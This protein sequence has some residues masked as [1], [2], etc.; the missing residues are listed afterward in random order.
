MLDVQGAESVQVLAPEALLIFLTTETEDE[1]VKRLK[2]R[3]GA[4]KEDLNL[5]IAMARQELKQISRFDYVVVNRENQLDDTVDTIEAIIE[6]E[7]HGFITERLLYEL[8]DSWSRSLQRHKVTRQR[9]AQ[10]GTGSHK[11]AY[12]HRYSDLSYPIMRLITC[13]EWITLLHLA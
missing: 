10:V 9:T 13:L 5:R 11:L 12:G 4:E 3:K 1:L 6:A 7:H 8:P 2:A